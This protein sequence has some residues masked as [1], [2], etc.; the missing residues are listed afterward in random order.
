MANLLGRQAIV[1]GA[2]IAGLVT[3]KAMSSCFG[4]VTILERDALPA[5]ATA[6]PGTPQAR[7]IHVLL[8]GGLDAL[9][10]VFP[11]LEPDLESAGAVRV[12]LG[13][14]ARLETPDV[15]HFPRRDLGFDYWSMTRP[16]LEAVL[17]LRARQTPNVVLKPRTRAVQV[18][19]S[20]DGAAATGVR[21][22]DAD[23]ENRE[24][25]ADLVVDASSRGTLTLE[26]LD[27]IGA[28]RPPETE[29]GIDLRYATAM[30]EIPSS[31]PTEWRAVL[32]RPSLDTGRGGLLVPVEDGRWQVN[33]TAMHGEAVPQ[34][35]REFVA[36]A[37]TLRTPTIYDAIARASPTGRVDRFGFPSSLRRHFEKLESFP[38]GLLPIGDAICR[39][40]P[41]FGQGMS[42][43]AQEVAILQRLAAAR[44]AAPDP[45]DGLA[46]SFFA[47]I[48]AV[49]VAPWSVAEGDFAYPGTRGQRPADLAL[50]LKFN[51]ALQRLAVQDAAVQQ[52]MSEVNHLLRPPSAL[53]EPPIANRVMAMMASA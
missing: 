51:A 45:L 17:R 34:T 10:G 39:F 46:V 49:L 47:A 22:E 52:V 19:A 21:F 15:D 33:L 2:G 1:I 28:S 40:N 14:E 32:H 6:R 31:A 35:H 36:F 8:R 18:L 48:Q 12:R 16:V 43:A 23:G 13:S 44:A 5:T 20:T 3:A 29:I 25:A 26:F 11:T 4:R 50:R 24:L 7:Q 37:K 30:F 9:S 41:A 53:R 38:K 27:R 42:V